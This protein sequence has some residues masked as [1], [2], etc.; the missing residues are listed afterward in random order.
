ML[1]AEVQD[2]QSV[3]PPPSTAQ[4]QERFVLTSSD[5]NAQH[6]CV[7]SSGHVVPDVL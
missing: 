1:V 4:Q 2:Q 7:L 6:S 5:Q 3:C